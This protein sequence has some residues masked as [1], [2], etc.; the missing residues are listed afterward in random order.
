MARRSI[1]AIR[2]GSRR[3]PQL[4][5]Q[6]SYCSNQLETGWFPRTRPT[7]VAWLNHRYYKFK[8]TGGCPRGAARQLRGSPWVTRL[9]R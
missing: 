6:V 1:S 8:P 3:F 9:L 2:A 4:G 5:A 7:S